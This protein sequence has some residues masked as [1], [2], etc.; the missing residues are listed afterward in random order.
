MKSNWIYNW[1]VSF[2]ETKTLAKLARKKAYNS[3]CLQPDN[4]K[5]HT[6]K[7]QGNE[8]V[9]VTNSAKNNYFKS[10]QKYAKY[11]AEGAVAK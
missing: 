9:L 4:L 5:I 10:D 11:I 3:T 6:G 1:T 8:S 2:M 7:L